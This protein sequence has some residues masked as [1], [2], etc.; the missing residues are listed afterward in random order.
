MIKMIFIYYQMEVFLTKLDIIL[1][2]MAMMN[3]VVIMMIMENILIQL[4]IRKL[5]IMMNCVVQTQRKKYRNKIII[6]PMEMEIIL[7]VKMTLMRIKTIIL[8]RMKRILGLRESIVFPHLFGS[9][10]NL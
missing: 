6:K 2:K 9:K 5:I 3:M 1:T 8:I 7:I 10:N 4:I